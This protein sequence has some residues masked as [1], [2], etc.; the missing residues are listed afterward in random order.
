M[1]Y[2]DE[3]RSTSSSNSDDTPSKMISTVET[4]DIHPHPVLE[5]TPDDPID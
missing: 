5:L 1:L 2:K 4:K 3:A